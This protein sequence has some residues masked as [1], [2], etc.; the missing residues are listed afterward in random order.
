MPDPESLPDPA[1]ALRTATQRLVRGVDQLVDDDWSAPSLLAGWSRAHVVAH[2]T[3][4]AEALANA[5]DGV[6]DNE[7]VLMYGSLQA[8][9]DDIEELARWQP[10]DLRERL[11]GSTTRIA[12]ALQTL[13]ALPPELHA[14]EVE[15]H[16]G[17]PTFRLGQVL[18]MRLLEVEVHHV[19][20]D[21][22][23]RPV[24]WTIGFSTLLLDAMAARPTPPGNV[25][26]APSDEARR[27]T[28]GAG[29]PVVTGPAHALAWWSTGR[30]AGPDLTSENGELPRIE[31]W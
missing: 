27:W 23:Y 20:L 19:D 31:T 6:R 18:D 9:D 12:G 11:L 16:P 1:S 29:G 8:R 14:T 26:M 7:A 17:G 25:V 13:Q 4:H 15:R 10:A 21:T 24:R 2:L 22:G 3:L 5:V 30:P 28:F